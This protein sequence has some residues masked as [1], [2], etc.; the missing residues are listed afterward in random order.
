LVALA[1][2]EGPAAHGGR[3]LQVERGR[4][5][6]P[7]ASLARWHLA[8]PA[9]ATV[10][11]AFNA[12][13]YFPGP[14][15]LGA[16]VLC[17]LLVLRVTLAA[18]PF[19]GWSP[20]LSVA[21]AALGLLATWMLASAGWSDA[22][23][24]ALLEF[25][26]VLLY[27]LALAFLGSFAAAPGDLGT[28]LRWLWVAL[29]AICIAGLATRLLPADFTLAPRPDASRLDHPVTYWN[30][31]GVVAMVGIV[32]SLHL[33]AAGT[34]RAWARVA[35]AAALPVF[36]VTLYFTF[37]RG[38]MAAGAGAVVVY[39]LLAHPRRL[40]SALPAMV[41]AVY[42]VREAYAADVLATNEYMNAAGREEGRELLWVLVACVGAAVALRLLGLLADRWLDGLKLPRLR[43]PA[44]AAAG[45][46]AVLVL[47]GAAAAADLPQ[48]LDDQREAFVEGDV[49]DVTGD[50]RDRLGTVG[51]NGRVRQ[52][53]IAVDEFEAR[54]WQGDGA[55]TYQLAW[56]LY[57][58]DAVR[59]V[60]G[61]SLYLEV[62]AEL[63]IPG[64]ALL[65]IALATLM[66]AGLWR[67]RGAER[68]AA[69]AFVAAGAGL[70]VHAGVDWDWEMV[71]L[72]VWFFAA[73]GVVAARRESAVAA[74]GAT[75]RLARVLA[76]LAVLIVA[77]TPFLIWRSQVALERGSRAFAAGD[78]TRA[79]D[80]ALDSLDRL[81]V[82][83]APYAML[84]YCNL[85]SGQH[86]LAVDAM[87][88]ARERDPNNWEYAYGVAVAQAI[89]G[90]DPLDAAR[91]AVELNPLEPLAL[92]LEQKLSSARPARWPAIAGRAQIPD[93]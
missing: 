45:V 91:A 55:G 70:L 38:S 89:A 37:S 8:V 2:R 7:R 76:G 51:N 88:R 10:Y 24:R 66:A 47:A 20:W 71:V 1:G 59:V 6:G 34:E 4:L 21:C 54:P 61:H 52:W 57:R 81:R 85:R 83:A 35:G 92:D 75:P 73:G 14:V 60:D 43:G 78:C 41:P 31:L 77:L 13:G 27:L 30:A 79:V 3:D 15:A 62:A 36:A 80:G 17:L 25:D 48:R 16:V 82:R 39:L 58:R 22:P 9:V 44:L 29:V 72:F 63:G 74:G 69:A 42:A 11:L 93:N 32:L 50:A 53:R 86:R 23:E 12:G 5:S 84:G 67:L 26:R 46:L 90:E 18:R 56:E 28:L 19:A 64:L 68:Y 49:V 87:E 33:T 65:G 40:L